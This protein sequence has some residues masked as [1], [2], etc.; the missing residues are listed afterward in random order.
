[1]KTALQVKELDYIANWC[2]AA[3][4]CWAMNVDISLQPTSDATAAAT[5][6]ALAATFSPFFSSYCN[7]H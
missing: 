1:M 3:R 4:T 2:V 6:A 7:S 5:A